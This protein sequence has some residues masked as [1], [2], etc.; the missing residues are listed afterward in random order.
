MKQ[1]PTFTLP[2]QIYSQ[3]SVLPTVLNV[4][5]FL[6]FDAK[7]DQYTA[8]THYTRYT[9]RNYQPYLTPQ[10]LVR[11]DGAIQIKAHRKIFAY[12]KWRGVGFEPKF[13]PPWENC[14][15]HTTNIR[16]LS[17]DRDHWKK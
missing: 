2:F 8:H 10:P 4:N 15:C 6:N 9:Y 5:D 13:S 3:V 12:N 11:G 17:L 14:H 7:V 1:F 16:L